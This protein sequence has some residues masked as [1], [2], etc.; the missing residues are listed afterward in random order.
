MAKQ[1]HTRK[2]GLRIPE[3][4][5]PKTM[6]EFRQM[7]MEQKMRQYFPGQ[8]AGFVPKAHSMTKEAGT[9]DANPNKRKPTNNE[10]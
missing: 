8:G 4:T 6:D 7:M 10:R 1:K 5:L 2:M 3:V 9:P